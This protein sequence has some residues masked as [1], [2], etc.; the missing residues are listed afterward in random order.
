MAFLNKLLA[1]KEM[2]KYINREK[3]LKSE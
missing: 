2:N 1:G 3:K